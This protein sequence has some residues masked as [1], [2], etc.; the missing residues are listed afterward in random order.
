MKK[1][2]LY[3]IK[4]KDF[5]SAMSIAMNAGHNSVAPLGMSGDTI[6][7]HGERRVE[8]VSIRLYCGDPKLLIT[9][10]SKDFL[11]YGRYDIRM[12]FD[13]VAKEYFRIFK[14]LRDLIPE[15]S[16]YDKKKIIVDNAKK[17]MKDANHQMG[18]R[19]RAN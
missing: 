5:R 10:K 4:L 16:K 9:N 14:M 15:E 6:M 17:S 2:N 3:D 12:G 19:Q 11:F 8:E 7:L 13:K 1:D 18:E